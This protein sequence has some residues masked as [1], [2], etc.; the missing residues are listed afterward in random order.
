MVGA[1]VSRVYVLALQ[2]PYHCRTQGENNQF[3]TGFVWSDS[4]P[5]KEG[6]PLSAD[7][8]FGEPGLAVVLTIAINF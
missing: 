4:V 7:S 2:G 3:A 6:K 1:L 5:S 8:V